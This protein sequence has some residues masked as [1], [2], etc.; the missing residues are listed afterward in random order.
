LTNQLGGSRRAQKINRVRQ[1][2][3]DRRYAIPASLTQDHA[4]AAGCYRRL[5]V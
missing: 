4:D 3:D 2:R 1:T 5:G